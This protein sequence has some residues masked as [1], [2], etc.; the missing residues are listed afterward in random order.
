MTLKQELRTYIQF[1]SRRPRVKL[2]LASA[3]ETSKL[4]PGDKP[5]PIRPRL[6][7]IPNRVPPTRDQGFNYLS[8]WSSFSLNPPHL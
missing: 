2:G 8:P 4:I 3:I 6:L 1:T 5:P 7:I